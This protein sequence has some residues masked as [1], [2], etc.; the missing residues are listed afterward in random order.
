MGHMDVVY[1]RRQNWRSVTI[2]KEGRADY[3]LE[4]HDLY[5]RGYQSFTNFKVAKKEAV[6]I[7]ANAS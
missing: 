2:I 4:T 1:H 3:K 6:R 7:L 5:V